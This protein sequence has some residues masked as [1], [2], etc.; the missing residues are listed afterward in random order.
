[1]KKVAIGCGVVALVVLLA[2]IGGGFWLARSARSYIQSYAELAQVAEL[3]QRVVNRTP[4]QPPGDQR[5][6]AAQL[7][8]YVNVQRAMLDHLGNRMRELDSKYSQLSASLQEQGRDANIRELLTAWRD[9]VSLV[10]SAKEAQVNALNAAGFS[11]DEYQWIRQQVLMALG[12]GF[13][14]LNLEAIAEDPAKLLE[15]L[16]AP[17]TPDVDVLQ[18]NRDLLRQYE[19][20]YEDWLPL[21]FFGL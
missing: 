19:D 15:A 8:R 16:E 21:S 5:L 17:D 2:L 1:M 3:N 10:V 14:G 20:T 13:L 9:V 6:T 11:L 18:F 12:Y 7:D 4:F